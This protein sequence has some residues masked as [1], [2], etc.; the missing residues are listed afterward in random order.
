MADD[1]SGE[2]GGERLRLTVKTT[3]DK[4]EVEVPADYT[5]KEV[6]CPASYAACLP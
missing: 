5:V 4:I 2:R 1:A 6:F 3:K